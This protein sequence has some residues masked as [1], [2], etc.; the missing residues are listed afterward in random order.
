MLNF[1]GRTAFVTGGGNGIG[2]GLARA[3]C[4][5]TPSTAAQ[6]G[7]GGAVSYTHRV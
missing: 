7:S 6:F 2:L 4:K 5:H 1:E 3:L